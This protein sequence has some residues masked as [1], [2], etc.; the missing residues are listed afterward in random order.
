M[1]TLST[2]LLRPLKPG[3]E[4]GSEPGFGKFLVIKT[5]VRVTFWEI[6]KNA[7]LVY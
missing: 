6:A 7:T 4:P 3:S 2:L 5:G 1:H